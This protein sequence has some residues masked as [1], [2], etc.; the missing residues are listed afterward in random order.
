M[1]DPYAVLGVSRNATDE[2]IKKAYRNLSRKY[3]PD[4][5]INNPN[6]EQAEERFKEVQQAYDEIM[7]QKQYGGGTSYGEYQSGGY[8]YGQ[9][10]YGGFGGYGGYQEAGSN[11]DQSIKMQAAANYIRNRYYKEAINVLEGM[12]S[13]E[14][15]GQWYYYCA[16][17]HNGLGN[18]ATAMEMAQRAVERE[19]SNF[20]YR[21]FLEYLQNGG[22]WYQSMGQSY[23]SPVAGV[24]RWCLSMLLLN[25]FCNLFCCG[26]GFYGVRM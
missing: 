18:N 9:A 17:A 13:A 23:E 26:N 3:H 22:T 24:G 12:E 21:Q 25:L 20:Q 5:N 8:G 4:A 16:V 19:P 15:N 11:S 1:R 10:G 14:R 6:K 2:E 7:H